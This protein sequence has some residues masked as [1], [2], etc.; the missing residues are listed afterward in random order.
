MTEYDTE[1]RM[2]RSVRLS[3]AYGVLFLVP[4]L[5]G[6]LLSTGA[7]R[8]GISMGNA[9]L[10]PFLGPWSAVLPPNAHRLAT[11]DPMTLALTRVW[12]LA[13]LG[14]LVGSY[15]S[16]RPWLTM[17]TTMLSVSSILMWVLLGIGRVL[18]QMM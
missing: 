13:F 6:A 1:K 8:G 17:L 12:T 18:S 5:I 2:S 9:F 15:V 14:A 3:I 4:A 10:A 16:K 7:Q 11:W